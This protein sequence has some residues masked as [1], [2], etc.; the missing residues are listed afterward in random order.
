MTQRFWNTSLWNTRK[1]TRFMKNTRWH[2]RYNGGKQGSVHLTPQGHWGQ[3]YYVKRWSTA[4][5]PITRPFTMGW[6]LYWAALRLIT[7][8]LLW[9]VHGLCQLWGIWFTFVVQLMGWLLFCEFRRFRS[10]HLFQPFFSSE[11]LLFEKQ[12]YVETGPAESTPCGGHASPKSI[13]FC[14]DEDTV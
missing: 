12:L 9:P 4:L 13:F 2:S 3:S 8:W 5:R 1:K 14:M 6:L 10:F 11:E 7:V